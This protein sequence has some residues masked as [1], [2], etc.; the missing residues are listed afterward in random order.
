MAS[1][2]LSHVVGSA[3]FCILKVAVGVLWLFL[4]NQQLPFVVFHSS[5]S[6][7]DFTLADNLGRNFSLRS[8]SKKSWICLDTKV[9]IWT[10]HQSRRAL[11]KVMVAILYGS[12]RRNH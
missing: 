11:N 4:E 12:Q 5:I 6:I 2:R 3:T 8:F 1:F 10:F 7:L 9:L